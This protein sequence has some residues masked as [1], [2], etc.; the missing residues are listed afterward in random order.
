MVG[1]K[2]GRLSSVEQ[3]DVETGNPRLEF[4]MFTVLRAVAGGPEST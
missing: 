3:Q 2:A 1:G 4:K